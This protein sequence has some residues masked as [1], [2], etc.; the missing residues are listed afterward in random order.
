MI[1][2]FVLAVALQAGDRE[3]DELQ[4]EN[5]RKWDVPAAPVLTPEEELATFQVA[6]GFVVELVAAEPLVV[7]PVAAVFDEEGK[8]W[9]AEMRGFMP[10]VDGVG[11]ENPVGKIVVLEDLNGDGIMDKSTPFLENLV[12]PRALAKVKGGL[13]VLAPPQL[14]FCEDLD[15]DDRCDKTTVVSEGWSGIASPEH[16]PNGLMH[17]MDNRLHFAKHGEE[18]SW[19]NGTWKTWPVPAQGQWGITMDDFGRLYFNSNSSFLHTDLVPRIYGRRNPGYPGLKGLG[20]RIM[21][22]QRVWPSRMN[23]GVNRGYRKSSLHPD[24]KLKTSDATCGPGVIR[25]SAFSKE[26]RGSVLLPEPAGN[27]VKRVQLVSKNGSV[28]AVNAHA[29]GQEFWTST[30]ERFRPVNVLEGPGGATYV[31][32]LY[33]GIL[34]HRVFV[35]SYLRKQILHRGLDKPVGLGRIWRVRQVGET[36]QPRIGQGEEGL[37]LWLRTLGHADGFWRDTAQRVLIESG[38]LSVVPALEEKVLSGKPQVAL[39]ALW[40]LHGLGSLREEIALHAVQSLPSGEWVSGIR[41]AEGLLPG[42]DGALSQ[43]ILIRAQQGGW[44]MKRQAVLSLLSSGSDSAQSAALTLFFEN[45]KD[46]L[47]LSCLPTTPLPFTTSLLKRLI[48]DPR[49]S[50]ENP[51]MRKIHDD[52]VASNQMLQVKDSK[53]PVYARNCLACHGADGLGQPALAPP[54]NDPA[55]LSKPKEELAMIVLDGLDGEIKVHGQAWDLAMPG[56]KSI[57]SNEEIAEVLTDI[58]R[59]FA[60]HPKVITA[61][62]VAGVRKKLGNENAH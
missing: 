38:N 13:L 10:N 15:G 48:S 47:L 43:E 46:D 32:D 50:L 7:D 9:V 49:F 11:E 33:R 62:D 6:D 61:Q 22:D 23:P 45:Y 5:W 25:G 19:E 34:Q 30:D 27:L 35:T 17:G 24:G 57:L 40:A 51:R 44:F 18:A 1:L 60:E 42:M 55:W 56:W 31:L 3:N 39:H 12:L 2:S 4:I 52:I 54:L 26:V 41:A 8:L 28:K 16:A 21:Q 37:M 36:P 58:Q 20:A 14:L 59:R 53:S 29:E